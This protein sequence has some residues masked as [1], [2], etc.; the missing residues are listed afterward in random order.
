MMK[1][2]LIILFCAVLGFLGAGIYYD[3][4]EIDTLWRD[5]CYG[6]G[7]LLLFFVLMPL[8]LFY[9]RNKIQMNKYVL[10]FSKRKKD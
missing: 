6:I 8:F 5:R 2:V 10:D 7:T 3:F 9:R 1:Y 4:A